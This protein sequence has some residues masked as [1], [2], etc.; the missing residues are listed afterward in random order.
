MTRRVRATA[1][2]NEQRAK[3]ITLGSRTAERGDRSRG[4]ADCHAVPP[5][6]SPRRPGGVRVGKPARPRRRP[7]GEGR[8]RYD[9][10]REHDGPPSARTRSRTRGWPRRIS[11]D[12]GRPVTPSGPSIRADQPSTGTPEHIARWTVRP[13]T[14]PEPF[15]IQIQRDDR[16]S[17]YILS[18]DPNTITRSRRELARSAR[19]RLSAS[20][21]VVVCEPRSNQ[22]VLRYIPSGPPEGPIRR[23]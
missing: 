4:H 15:R 10:D 23:R 1:A 8:R 14:P 20:R 16:V 5:S 19:P 3:P 22:P 17:M 2:R 9:A 6:A 21:R 7:D 18:P 13:P 11:R 12:R